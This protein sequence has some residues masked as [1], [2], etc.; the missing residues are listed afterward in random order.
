MDYYAVH[1]LIGR[2]RLCV[3]FTEKIE[4]IGYVA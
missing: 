4:A 1:K 2:D 3:S